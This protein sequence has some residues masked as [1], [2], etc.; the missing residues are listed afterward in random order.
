MGS[1]YRSEEMRFC[2]MIVE[3]DAAFF[4]VSE[5]GKKPYVEFKD[6]GVFFIKKNKNFNDTY[7]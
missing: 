4:C 3:K 7:S 5:L 2:Q 1:L 6:V